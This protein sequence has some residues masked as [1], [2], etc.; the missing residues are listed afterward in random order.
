MCG[1]TEYYARGVIS[2][3]HPGLSPHPPQ[4][5][6]LLDSRSTGRRDGGVALR[7]ARLRRSRLAEH[8]RWRGCGRGW[9]SPM[10][11]EICVRYA[12]M[13]GRP[14]SE[15]RTSVRRRMCKQREHSKNPAPKDP[16]Q[17]FIRD[18]QMMD[19]VSTLCCARMGPHVS[20]MA[21]ALPLRRRLAV[22]EPLWW[23]CV[24]CQWRHRSSVDPRSST[25]TSLGAVNQQRMVHAAQ[26]SGAT[27]GHRDGASPGLA[28]HARHDAVK[29]TSNGT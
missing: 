14:R 1:R 16:S 4:S 2:C 7:G 5:S 8:K 24:S 13:I 12:S 9:R 17:P 21:A 26:S 27:R 15:T 6:A 19:V 22:C 18:D 11:V 3:R 10:C 29:H 23:E 25:S 20:G 28:L